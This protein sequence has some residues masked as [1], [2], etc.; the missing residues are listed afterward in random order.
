MCAG[1]ESECVQVWRV[2]AGVESECV[3]GWRVSVGVSVCRG[4]E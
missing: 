4:G 1:V 3:Q 2:C